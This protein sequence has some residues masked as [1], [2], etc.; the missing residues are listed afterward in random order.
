MS[1]AARNPR[2]APRFGVVYRP[3]FPPETL[4]AIARAVDEASIAELWLWEDC[5]LQGAVAQAAVALASS[6]RLSVGIGLVPA[7]LRSV[8]A[9]A[10]EIATLARIYPGR[11]KLG[12]GNG[13]QDWMSQA[14]VRVHSPLT[15]LREYVSALRALLDGE[16]VTRS[17]RYVELASVRLSW[18]P[19]QPVPILVGGSGPKTLRLAPQVGQGVIIDCQNTVASVRATLTDISGCES[20]TETTSF[21][22]V[23]YL[24]CAP[25][26]G[27]RERLRAEATRWN[28]DAAAFGVGGTTGEIREGIARYV[29][30]GIDTVVL[31][32]IGDVSEFEALVAAAV[33]V[34]RSWPND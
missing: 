24:P 5:F 23:M 30:V 32:P 16:S 33:A 3:D 10:M 17:G 11:V 13:V 26:D 7:P 27:A 19:P 29:D 20:L 14:G 18:V 15:L 4:P 21:A 6:D 22:R 25:G 1:K 31:Q 34:A 2:S 9:T 12:I 8:V 28:V